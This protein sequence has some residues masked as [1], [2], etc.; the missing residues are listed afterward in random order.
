LLKLSL[1]W[2][3]TAEDKYLA[4][5]PGKRPGT[6]TTQALDVPGP[7]GDAHVPTTRDATPLQL[8]PVVFPVIGDRLALRL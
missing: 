7:T 4:W 5:R 2:I 8:A 1:S 6:P 3:K